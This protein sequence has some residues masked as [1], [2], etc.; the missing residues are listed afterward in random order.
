VTSRGVATFESHDVEDQTSEEWNDRKSCLRPSRPVPPSQRTHFMVSVKTASPA[1]PYVERCS[2]CSWIDPTALQWW[3]DNAVKNSLNERARR[4]AVAA[5]TEPFSF[6]NS[7][8]LP[9][10]DLDEILGQA[11]GAASMC[12]VGG[13][14]DLEFDSTRAKAIW[15]ALRAEVDRALDGQHSEHT[16]EKV[17]SELYKAGLDQLTV[18]DTITGMQNSGILFRERAK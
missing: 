10:P 3:A 2:D 11:L 7:A 14:G 16:L 12:W 1:V 5:E 8:G 6:V 17:R 4:I 18:T 13:T 15:E 9:E